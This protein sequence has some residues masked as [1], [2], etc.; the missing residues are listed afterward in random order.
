MTVNQLIRELMQLTIE[1]NEASDMTIYINGDLLTVESMEFDDPG[2]IDGV[3]CGPTVVM[4]T[5]SLEEDED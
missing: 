1:H 5:Y 2:Q 3:S 4:N